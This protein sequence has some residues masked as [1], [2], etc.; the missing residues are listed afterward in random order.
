MTIMKTDRIE[1]QLVGAD[2][3]V[4]SKVKLLQ[5]R[6]LQMLKERKDSPQRTLMDQRLHVHNQLNSTTLVLIPHSL[7]TISIRS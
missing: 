1:D 2:N 6:D 5:P 3:S 7:K 4:I